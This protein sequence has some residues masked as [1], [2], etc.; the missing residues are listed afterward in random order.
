M[1]PP[2]RPTSAPTRVVLLAG[3]SGCGKSYIARDSG[4]PIVAL[5]DFYRDATEPGLPRSPDGEVDWEDPTSWDRA[6]ALAAL[7]Q[8][9]RTGEVD[10]PTYSFARSEAV[11]HRLLRTEGS[12]VVVAE[13]IFAAELIAPLREQGLLADALLI[14]VDRWLTYVRRL[15]RDAR[16]GRKALPYLVRQGWAKTRAEPAVVAHQRAAGARPVTK[17]EALARLAELATASSR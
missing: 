9:C 7:D 17:A 12:P 13:G 11:G 14:S 16:E 3:P 1:S 15:V 2:D 6:A 4:L 5:D 8:L 10:V